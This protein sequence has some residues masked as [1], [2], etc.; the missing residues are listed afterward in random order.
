MEGIALKKYISAQNGVFGHY[1][2]FDSDSDSDSSASSDIA[3]CHC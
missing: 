2:I 1:L 3:H